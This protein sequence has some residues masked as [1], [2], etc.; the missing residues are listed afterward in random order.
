MFLE[1]WTLTVC[2]FLMISSLIIWL[3]LRSLN[4]QVEAM[5]EKINDLHQI[6]SR[7]F[8]MIILNA[9]A[10][11]DSTDLGAPNERGAQGQP[12]GL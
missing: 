3:D 1:S 6:Q 4:R 8:N 9:P 7:L 11:N 10:K 5:N 2:I 12:P